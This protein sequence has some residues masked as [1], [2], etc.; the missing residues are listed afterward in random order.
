MIRFLVE[1]SSPVSN[2]SVENVCVLG[3]HGHGCWD[4]GFF[5]DL[6][7]LLRDA[8]NRNPGTDLLIL[9]EKCQQ[10]IRTLHFIRENRNVDLPNLEKKKRVNP[11][12]PGTLPHCLSANQY[13]PC[14][15]VVTQGRT[16]RRETSTL[17]EDISR[18]RYHQNDDISLTTLIDAF[19]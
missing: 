6:S 10:S 7:L 18:T 8:E 3:T 4:R 12:H 5:H 2:L 9:K 16:H 14:R 19:D 17:R 13:F 15:A 11:G 1:I